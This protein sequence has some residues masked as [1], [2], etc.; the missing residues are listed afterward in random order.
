MEPIWLWGILGL[1]L[2][3]MEMMNETFYILWFGIAA[4]I[5]SVCL[6]F[7]PE[8]HAGWQFLIFAIFSLGSLAIWKIYYRKSPD[9]DLKVGQSQGDEVGR[10]GTIVEAVNR[11]QNGRIQ[12]AQ[13]VMGSKE[14]TAISE[15]ELEIGSEA[16]IT[17]VVGNAMT[18]KRHIP[19]H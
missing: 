15:E 9:L 13:G 10:I 17:A 8:L 5:V 3:A 1:M 12:F 18:V 4:L 6:Y 11:K 14:W 19:S 2:V 7:F 16:E